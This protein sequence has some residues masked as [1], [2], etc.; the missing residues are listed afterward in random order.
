MKKG[1]IASIIVP[2]LNEEQFIEKSLKALLNQTVPKEKYEI[3]VSDS[4][5][6]DSTVEIAKRYADKVVACK[7]RS[8]GFGRNFGAEHASTEMLGFVDAD[9]IV[10]NTWVEG[11]MEGLQQSIAC[12]GPIEA[13]EKD[14]L[15]MR[16]FYRWWDLQ[17]RLSVFFSYPVFPGFNI[18]V[19]KKEF[20]SVN[21]FSTKN[22]TTEDIE[23]GHKLNKLGKIVFSKK[24]KVRTSTRRLKDISVLAYVGNGITFALFKKSRQWQ[25]HRKDF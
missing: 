18:G 3:I 25:E 16:I 22:I 8:A 24:M 7:R 6:S 15:K 14:S 10:E 4:S 5:S 12:T 1:I 13:L 11:L 9:T 23:L 19:R 20:E 2:T 17:S 21:G